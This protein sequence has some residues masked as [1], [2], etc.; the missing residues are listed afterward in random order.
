MRDKQLV[1]TCP[2]VSRTHWL[3]ATW[4]ILNLSLST[5]VCTFCILFFFFQKSFFWSIQLGINYVCCC[6]FSLF[7][8]GSR[9]RGIVTHSRPFSFQTAANRGMS[10]ALQHISS[11]GFLMR[12]P[13]EMVLDTLTQLSVCSALSSL[14]VCPSLWHTPPHTL[15]LLNFR[16]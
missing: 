14:S 12:G 13:E 1:T 10:P 2:S 8:T 11:S 3:A 5:A 9:L 15:L 6:K 7:T 4:Y 16:H